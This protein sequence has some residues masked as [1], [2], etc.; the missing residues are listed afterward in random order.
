M[1]EIAD[2]GPGLTLPRSVRHIGPG[3]PRAISQGSGA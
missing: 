2:N 3:L 1:P